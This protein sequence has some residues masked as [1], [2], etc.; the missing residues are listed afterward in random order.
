MPFAAKPNL[1]GSC[2]TTAGGSG[3]GSVGATV[4]ATE[5]DGDGDGDGWTE[6]AADSDASA[7][8]DGEGPGD[9]PP[10]AWEPGPT[11]LPGLAVE[12]AAATTDALALG[13][14]DATGEQAASR[15][16]RTTVAGTNVRP[17]D[18]AGVTG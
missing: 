13:V 10:G 16:A 14:G 15:R 2:A 11:E 5:A 7:D 8:G 12:L 6:G 18:R 4:G 9:E 3:G 17:R 1:R